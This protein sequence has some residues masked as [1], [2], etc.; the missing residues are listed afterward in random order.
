MESPSHRLTLFAF[1]TALFIASACNPPATTKM[2]PKGNP[3]AARV[4]GKR[5]GSLSYRVSAP[6]QSFNYL[7]VADEASLLLAFYLLGGRLAEYDCDKGAYA[8]G[9]AEAWQLAADGRTLNLT[10]RDGVKFS[11]GHPLTAEDVEFTFRALYDKRTAS[12]I[13]RDAMLIDEKQIEVSVLD[14]RHLRLVFPVVTVTPENYLSNLAVLPRH[15]L[16]ADFNRGTLRDAYGMA[17]DPKSV[18]TAGA[19]SVFAALPGERITLK[20]NSYYWKKD[21]AGTQLPYL[22]QFV[23][24]IV[25]DANNA[26]VRLNQGSLDLI[27]RIRPTD[28]AA[29]RSKQGEV[30]VSDAGAGLSTDHLWFNLHPQADATKRSWFDDVRFRRAVSHA[31]DRNSIATV[32]LQGLATPLLGFLSPGNR[33]WVAND[34][35]RTDFDLAKARMALSEAGFTTRGTQ[36]E[37]ELFDSKGNRV[38]FT[39]LVP[40]G[41]QPRVAM[42]TVV[43]EDLAKLGIKMQVA[44]LEFGDMS[45]RTSESLEYDAAL[46][47]ISL[48]EPDPSSYAN[49]LLSSGLLH[50]WNPKQSRPATP[51][52]AR[53]DELFV[54]QSREINLERRHALFREIQLILAEQLPVIP[55]VARHLAAAVNQR[56]GNH[57]PSTILPYSLWNAEELFI[58]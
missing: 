55:I 11:D 25:S 26:L 50:Q 7:K 16:E 20:R 43:Q 57:R 33:L 48:S 24:E 15:A 12:P 31:I 2:P 10:L 18:I 5:G 46:L 6:P 44:A 1:L 3:S 30:Q 47:G 35:P 23:F 9:V 8:P 52:E 22:D 39:L 42:A 32:T 56:I 13:F 40:T 28:Y 51:W 34:L 58:R 41:S 37:P 19:F 14:S 54:A 45:K 53:I 38:E 17:A 4:V 49:F 29:M 27:D 36:Q 21:A